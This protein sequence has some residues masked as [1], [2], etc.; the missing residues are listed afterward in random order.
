MKTRRLVL[1]T[2]ALSDLTRAEAVQVGG[3]SGYTCTSW[4]QNFTRYGCVPTL[5]DCVVTLDTTC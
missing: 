3:A 1:R 5:N 4:C 2:E